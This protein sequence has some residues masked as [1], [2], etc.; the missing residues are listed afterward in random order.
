MSQKVMGIG[1]GVIFLHLLT[2]LSHL[3][4]QD[5]LGPSFRFYTLPKMWV[6]ELKHLGV[7]FLSR[8]DNTIIHLPRTETRFPGEL[9]QTAC[10]FLG[11]GIIRSPVGS[12]W[13]FE[14]PCNNMNY[15][16]MS[17]RDQGYWGQVVLANHLHDR[18]KVKSSSCGK[19]LPYLG[20]YLKYCFVYLEITKPFKFPFD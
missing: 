9:P 11:G 12:Y 20:C 19:Y 6:P 8:K 14:N 18:G 16:K 3:T 4:A 15:S 10:F 7:S 1:D 5:G 17:S 13:A 2:H